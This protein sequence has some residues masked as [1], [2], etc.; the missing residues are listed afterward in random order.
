[1]YNLCSYCMLIFER[2]SFVRKTN[3][4]YQVKNIS[5]FFLWS[6]ISGQIH[7]KKF[8]DM[9]VINNKSYVCSCYY[10]VQNFRESFFNSIDPGTLKRC[11]WDKLA[12]FFLKF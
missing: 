3:E 10:T 5:S 6:I 9:Q 8:K 4:I 11:S 1:M 2:K 12:S 7:Q